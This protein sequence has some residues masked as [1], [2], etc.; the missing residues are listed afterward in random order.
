MGQ[1][2][3]DVPNDKVIH[4]EISDKKEYK[5]LINLLE[6]FCTLENRGLSDEDLDDIQ[7]ANQTLAKGDFI[8]LAEAE[9]FWNR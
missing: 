7:Y 2:I 6:E 8:T 5:D 3:I 4:F 1:I 9:S